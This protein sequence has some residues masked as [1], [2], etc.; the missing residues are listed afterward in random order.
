MCNGKGR[1]YFDPAQVIIVFAGRL[2]CL[3]PRREYSV[4]LMN[5]APTGPNKTRAILTI[6]NVSCVLG[7]Q[8]L[9]AIHA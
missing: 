9:F 8:K 2:D 5:V 4:L 3:E 7:L 1:M 6:I